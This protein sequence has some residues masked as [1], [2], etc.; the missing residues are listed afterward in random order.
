MT[1][2]LPAANSTGVIQQ[3]EKRWGNIIELWEGYAADP[4]IRF[5]GSSGGLCAALSLFCIE[6]GQAS[7]VLHIARPGQI[8]EFVR[9][10]EEEA[11]EVEE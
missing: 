2:V 6:K 9:G 7:G 1:T 3:L 10:L 8:R 5:K 11:K 4:E